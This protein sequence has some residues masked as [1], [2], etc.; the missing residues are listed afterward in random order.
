MTSSDEEIKHSLI[1]KELN[2]IISMSLSKYRSQVFIIS[3]IKERA[4]G[5][6]TH[7]P[8]D[9]QRVY[10][11]TIRGQLIT[12]DTSIEATILGL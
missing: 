8:K 2:A 1:R 6:I 3:F 5:L 10:I 7:L 12:P 4:A 11:N 9:E